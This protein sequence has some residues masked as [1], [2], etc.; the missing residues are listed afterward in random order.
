ML[1]G[2]GAWSVKIAVYIRV[3][4]DCE[5]QVTQNLQ[6]VVGFVRSLML[7][8]MQSEGGMLMEE[9][10]CVTCKTLGEVD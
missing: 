9:A 2:Q 1:R 3:H 4:E 10:H 8:V 6:Y 7:F 5:H